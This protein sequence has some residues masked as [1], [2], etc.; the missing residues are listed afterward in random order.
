MPS[1]S[2]GGR[3]RAAGS[4]GKV[5]QP[6]RTWTPPGER[7]E[8][9]VLEVTSGSRLDGSTG[10]VDDSMPAAVRFPFG[11]ARFQLLRCKFGGRFQGRGSPCSQKKKDALNNL[12]MIA[13]PE[14]C[15]LFSLAPSRTPYL[16]RPQPGPSIR[17]GKSLHL[18]PKALKL[19]LR[20][21]LCR[22]S[23]PRRESGRTMS[24]CT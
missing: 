18:T 5:S 23:G 16:D 13:G 1:P 19:I 21:L 14:A 6:R 22:L 4:D 12:H 2:L 10:V 9:A 8:S 15:G 17:L 11:C 7:R 3:A 24:M 20:D